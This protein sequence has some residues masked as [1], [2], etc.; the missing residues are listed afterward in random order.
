MKMNISREVIRTGYLILRL[1]YVITILNY[2]SS[3][4]ELFATVAY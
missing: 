2:L 1:E 4:V 3:E